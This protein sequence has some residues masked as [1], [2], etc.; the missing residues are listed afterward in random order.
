MELQPSAPNAETPH[1]NPAH[2]RAPYS[3]KQFC[4]PALLYTCNPRHLHPQPLHS[5]MPRLLPPSTSVLS[6]RSYPCST[7]FHTHKRVFGCNM[8]FV[9]DIAWVW[10]YLPRLHAFLAFYD[11]H[12]TSIARCRVHV[13][14]TSN[15][16]ANTRPFSGFSQLNALIPSDCAA[17]RA[18]YPTHR[19]LPHHLC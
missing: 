5:Y 12:P 7:P 10:A 18:F 17:A 9:K 1:D 19:H 15:I 4:T 8:Q 14:A 3:Y 13:H 2:A 11:V 6:F 16:C